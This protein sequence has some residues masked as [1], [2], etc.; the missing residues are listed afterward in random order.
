[1]CTGSLVS[2]G[3]KTIISAY[4]NFAGINYDL[5]ATFPSVTDPE[6]LLNSFSYPEVNGESC[7]SREHSGAVLPEFFTGTVIHEHTQLSNLTSFQAT[8]SSVQNIVGGDVEPH[9]DFNMVNLPEDHPVKTKLREVFPES[10][11]LTLSEPG[12]PNMLIAPYI[13]DAQADDI[14]NGGNGDV[15]LVFDNFGNLI[16]CLPGNISDSPILTPWMRCTREYHRIRYELINE[17]VE[18]SEKYMVSLKYGLILM[19]R[20][21]NDSYRDLV[22]IGAYGST[23]E[24]PLPELIWDNLQYIQ[25]STPMYINAYLE[26]MPPFYSQLVQMKMW[27]VEDIDLQ[28]EFLV[29]PPPIK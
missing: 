4:D 11:A 6:P 10:L 5:S 14:L 19:L 18:D 22:D 16:L 20:C 3:F 12:R 28:T 13:H 26:G 2:A 15:A 9:P 27:Q 17:E 23:M 25:P 24:G 8:L 7:L 29:V 1:M 21:P